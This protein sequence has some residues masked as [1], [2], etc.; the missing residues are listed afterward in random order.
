MNT[1]ELLK[2]FLAAEFCEVAEDLTSLTLAAAEWMLGLEECRALELRS[3][4]VTS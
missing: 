1:S 2:A 4:S 3:D